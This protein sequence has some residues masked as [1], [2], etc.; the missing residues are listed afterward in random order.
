MEDGKE[1][2]IRGPLKT[3]FLC[4]IKF[5]IVNYEQRDFGMV[6]IFGFSMILMGSWETSL[7]SE[8]P[9]P[10]RIRLKLETDSLM[11]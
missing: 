11:K 4:V 9:V 1:T 7:S 5:H 2:R 10:L 8:Q 6:S 3:F